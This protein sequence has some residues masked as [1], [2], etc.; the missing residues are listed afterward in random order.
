M[1][2]EKEEGRKDGRTVLSF[3]GGGTRSPMNEGD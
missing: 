3:L 1:R 2:E